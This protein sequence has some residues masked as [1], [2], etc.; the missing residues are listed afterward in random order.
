MPEKKE[1]PLEIKEASPHKPDISWAVRIISIL[2][3]LLL[4]GYVAYEIFLFGLF[5]YLTIEK[6]HELFGFIGATSFSGASIF[7]PANLSYTLPESYQ[8][9]MYI[10]DESDE[11]AFAMIGGNLMITQGLLDSAENEEELLFIL[12]HE[13]TH[14]RNQDALKGLINAAP[15]AVLSS[16]LGGES[17]ITIGQLTQAYQSYTSRKTEHQADEWGVA[18]LLELW[19]NTKCA[20]GFFQRNML[21]GEEY[22]EFFSS[23]P[24]NQK[25][26][27]YIASQAGEFA[28][29]EC[30][31]LPESSQ[32]EISEE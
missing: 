8:F 7:D 24:I 32:E 26:I 12:G 14:L 11:N 19:L 20:V 15:F 28:D 31:P 1:L 29:K 25:R 13:I 2:W 21:P 22:G 17:D 4:A 10:V 30:T 18:L 9:P 23:H 3:G 16:Y 27:E 5:H 6:E